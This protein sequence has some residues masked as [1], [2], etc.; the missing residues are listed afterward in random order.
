VGA[1]WWGAFVGAIEE[2][3]G[4]VADTTKVVDCEGEELDEGSGRM[5]VSPLIWI[6]ALIWMEN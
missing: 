5:Y 6:K 2:V 1:W 4:E 3:V